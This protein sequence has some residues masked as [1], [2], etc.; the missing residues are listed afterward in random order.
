MRWQ[1]L[2]D[3]L[4]AQLDA[5]ERSDFDAEVR[6]RTRRELALVA[7]ADRLAAAHG[8]PLAA[9][10][11]GPG[12][13]S[14]VLLDS[15]PDWALLDDEGREVL[16]PLAAVLHL[17]GVGAAAR[18]PGGGGAVA[19]ALDLRWALRGLARSRAPVQAVLRDGSGLTGTVDRVGTDHLDLAEHPADEVRRTASVRGVRVVPLPALALLRR[20]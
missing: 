2:F 15:G 4:E 3:D 14:G 20:L 9:R 1:A 10:I 5:A 7:L 18:P 17:S 16:V 13:V 11:W 6:D 12:P 8:Q 19:R